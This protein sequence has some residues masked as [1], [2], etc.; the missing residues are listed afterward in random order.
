LSTAGLRLRQSTAQA[1]LAPAAQSAEPSPRGIQSVTGPLLRSLFR[2]PRRH[3]AADHKCDHD[4]KKDSE[5]RHAV[6]PSP[7]MGWYQVLRSNTATLAAFA[8]ASL[9]SSRVNGF[10][11]G[12]RS[13][14]ADGRSLYCGR[15]H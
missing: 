14:A 8:A 6:S 12:A 2:S 11:H 5:F 15:A 7:C 10:F 1:G 4:G 3:T 13:R 9:A